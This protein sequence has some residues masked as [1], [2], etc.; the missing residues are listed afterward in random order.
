M[1]SSRI[2]LLRV[3]FLIKNFFNNMESL[4]KRKVFL[5][6]FLAIFIIRNGK[7]C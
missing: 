1:L 6:G 2:L 4:S 7:R 5:E 3:R